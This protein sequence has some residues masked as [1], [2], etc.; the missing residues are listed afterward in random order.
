MYITFVN[1]WIT[2]V[3]KIKVS[4]NRFRLGSS[5]IVVLGAAVIVKSSSHCNHQLVS[6]LGPTYKETLRGLLHI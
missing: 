6:G 5:C 4:L 1:S 3:A 2:N